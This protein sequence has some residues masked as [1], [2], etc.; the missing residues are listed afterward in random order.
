MGPLIVED[1]TPPDIDHDI[2]VLMSDW[3]M[4]QNGSLSD[5]FFEMHTVAHDGHMGN[6]A[7]AFL[8]KDQVKT[9][10][11]VRFRL[12]NAATNRI[13]PVAV[14]GV[15]GLVLALDGMDLIE[16]HPLETYLAFAPKQR[17]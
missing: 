16:P 9:G 8:S 11:R 6:L 3:Q 5:E 7:R 2:T 14:R 15:S 4:Q 10:D 1:E 17:F 12:I 13:F